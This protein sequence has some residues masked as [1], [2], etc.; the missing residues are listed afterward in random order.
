MNGDQPNGHWGVRWHPGAL[1]ELMAYTHARD[2]HAITDAVA[3]LEVRG[4]SLGWPHSSAIRG[5]DGLGLR[6]LRPRAG[7]CRWRPIYVRTGPMQLTV[8]AIAP[9]AG[10]NQRGFAAAVRRAATRHLEMAQ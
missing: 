8:L 7:R 2:R 3:K 5:R 4:A 9:E 1:E 6:Q 10:V